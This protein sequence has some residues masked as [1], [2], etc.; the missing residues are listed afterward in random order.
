MNKIIVYSI[1]AFCSV[2]GAIGQIL[3]SKASDSINLSKPFELITNY[4]LM[5][6]L[7]CYSISMIL[8]ILVLK[9]GEVSVLYPIIAL[10]YIW[11][12]FMSV[13][14]LGSQITLFK[15]IGVLL[16]IIG[17]VCIVR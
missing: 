11:V 5:I 13:W 3:F 16:I 2:L 10:S 4:S 12:M 6:G 15:S 7:V 17:V 8:Y 9:Y 1:V 14:F